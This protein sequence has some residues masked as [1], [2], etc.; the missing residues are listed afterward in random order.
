MLQAEVR[1]L[2]GAGLPGGCQ[3]ADA[4]GAAAEGDLR[5]RIDGGR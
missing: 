3:R 5:R 2:G 4:R 1:L